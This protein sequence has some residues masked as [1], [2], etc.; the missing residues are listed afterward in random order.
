[1]SSIAINKKT[2]LSNILNHQI[3]IHTIDNRYYVGTL[4]SFDKHMNLVLSDTFES[5]ITKKSYSQL[6]KHE[7]GAAPV[8]EKRNLGLIILRGEQI[9]SLTIESAAPITS[10]KDRVIKQPVSRKIKK[11]A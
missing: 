9:V 10:V 1:M 2:K 5:R 11:I 7:L 6:K 8:Y 4:L 3:K